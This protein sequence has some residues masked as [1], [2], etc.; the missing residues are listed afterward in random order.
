MKK[1]FF[2]QLTEVTAWAGFAIILA[3]IFAPSWVIIALGVTLICTDDVKAAAWV[4]Q[5]A[6]NVS[7]VIDDLCKQCVTA[8]KTATFLNVHRMSVF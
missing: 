4:K 6:P 7:K 8:G 3:A 1:W 2:T 5:K